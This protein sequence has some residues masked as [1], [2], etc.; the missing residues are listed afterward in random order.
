ME[1]RT[2]I[3]TSRS[4]KFE[5]GR[6]KESR[7]HLSQ[8][9]FRAETCEKTRKNSS[10]RGG[11]PH[12]RNACGNPW[13]PVRTRGGPRLIPGLFPIVG[14]ELFSVILIECKFFRFLRKTCSL[15]KI[16]LKPLTHVGFLGVKSLCY[17]EESGC[18]FCGGGGGA[19]R[20]PS[21]VLYSHAGP[22]FTQSCFRSAMP[23]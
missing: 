9:I 5:V 11:K 20:L 3:Q 4:W 17:Y 7:G 15:A 12:G 19:I 10:F 13:G 6:D 18:L 21:K 2:W 22:N 23:K 1:D 14:R 16:F 8:Y